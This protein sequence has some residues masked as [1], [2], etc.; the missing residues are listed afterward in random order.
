MKKA[1]KRLT[2]KDYYAFTINR[3]VKKCD[4]LSLL[5]FVYQFLAKSMHQ[6]AETTS[7]N[8]EQGK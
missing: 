6:T 5:D 4:D 7:E 1:P 3:L 8:K 2:Q